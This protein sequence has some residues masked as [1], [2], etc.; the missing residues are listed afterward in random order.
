MKRIG[1]TQ[2]VEVIAEYKERR[3]CLDQNWV[4][5]LFNLDYIPVLLPNCIPKESINNYLKDMSLD[6][7]ILTGGNDLSW[8]KS[9]RAAKE[10]DEFESELIKYCY[11]NNI[12]VLGVCRGMQ[13]LNLFFG[14][15]LQKVTHHVTKN[16][17][18]LFFDG[19][20]YSV[21]SYH[22]WGIPAHLLSKKLVACGHSEDGLVEYCKHN[23]KPL[24]GI[25]W[26]PERFNQDQAVSE[27]I[28]K[29]TFL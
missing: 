6:G 26:H 29:E 3:D 27:T 7:V 9:P 12:P 2:R 10:R 13:L 1:L 20:S 25:M 24:T 5:L 17:T 21:N 19:K 22:D 15:Q 16:H 8:T 11:D 18:V 23:E 14:G 4:K 28:I